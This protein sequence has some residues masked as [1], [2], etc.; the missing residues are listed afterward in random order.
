MQPDRKGGRDEGPAPRQLP[1][2][3]RIAQMPPSALPETEVPEL[4]ER[5]VLRAREAAKQAQAEAGRDA[6][7][8]LR[9]AEASLKRMERSDKRADR[10]AE[11]RARAVDRRIRRVEE[12]MRQPVWPMVAVVLV[13]NALASALA[14]GHL[15]WPGA[16]AY[17]GVL[18]PDAGQWEIASYLFVGASLG[19][20][21]MLA[22]TP[23]VD[24]Q[25]RARSAMGLYLA[26]ALLATLAGLLTATALRPLEDVE[27]DLAPVVFGLAIAAAVTGAPAVAIWLVAGMR[28]S[29]LPFHPAYHWTVG[30]LAAVAVCALVVLPFMAIAMEGMMSQVGL[31]LAVAGAV[32]MLFPL[33][34]ILGAFAAEYV[35]GRREGQPG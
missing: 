23:T 19:A 24:F 7:R 27:V 21:A 1:A 3:G 14:V 16:F 25:R 9:E 15:F 4:T 8:R 33:P 17:S 13:L 18:A 31:G 29:R 35:L 11:R 32:G 2:G 5:E 28:N 22:L 12:A 34:V 6:K 26:V 30:I 10:K 20:G